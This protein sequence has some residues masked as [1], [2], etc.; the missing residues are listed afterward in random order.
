MR[1]GSEVKSRT[2]MGMRLTMY[3]FT[4]SMLYFS[5]A[6]MG[7]MGEDSATV[8]FCSSQKLQ[9]KGIADTITFDERRYTFLVFER[10]SLFDEI[11]LV[12]QDDDVLQ[13]HDL[14]GGE[15]LGCL[16]LRTRL[17]P[18]DQK[19]RSVHDG[20]TVQH[21]GHE[22]VVAWTV[23]EGH[24]SHELVAAAATWSFARWVVFFVR[25]VRAVTARSRTRRIFAFIDLG[26]VQTRPHQQTRANVLWR[27][28]SQA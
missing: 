12:L 4:A 3:S 22:N 27:S 17:V 13:L 21:G 25:R 11:D 23:D 28:R 10:S 6:E 9:R 7:T 14:H 20:G 2:G 8:P 1:R 5:C 16:R 15:M 26:N 18:C 19:E 24:M